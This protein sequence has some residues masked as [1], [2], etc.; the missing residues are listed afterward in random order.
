[1]KPILYLKDAVQCV[2][3]KILKKHVKKTDAKVGTLKT[4]QTN[5]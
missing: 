1:M 5:E 4:K 2:S 3:Q